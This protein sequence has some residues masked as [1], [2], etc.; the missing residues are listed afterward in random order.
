MLGADLTITNALIL[1]RGPITLGPHNLNMAQGAIIPD[2][3]DSSHV[4]TN[5]TGELRSYGTIS[6]SGQNVVFPIGVTFGRPHIC[7]VM[8]SGTVDEFRA[9]VG[10]TVTS[11]GLPG[12]TPITS[13]VVNG[14]WHVSEGTP[15]GSTF[16]LILYW[17]TFHEATSF[18]RTRSFVGRIVS[19]A[20]Q[21][22]GPVGAATTI[23]TRVHR[24]LTGQTM[25][26]TYAVGDLQS[27]IPVEL[28]LFTARADG[29]DVVL[30]WETADERANAGFEVQRA[31]VDDDAWAVVAFVAARAAEGSGAKYETVD[32]SVAAGTWRYRLRQVDVDGRAEYSQAVT[33]VVGEENAAPL[34]AVHPNPARDVAQVVVRDARVV[35][36]RDVLGREVWRAEVARGGV[37]TLVVPTQFMPAGVYVVETD[38]AR[39]LLRIVR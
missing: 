39:T 19:G 11:N 21:P 30:A 1:S 15:G 29:A 14:M 2:D 37:Q 24:E 20:W 10:G 25:L 6:S 12:G 18:D 31:R 32:R 26:G 17:K 23:G 34:V 36:V 13:D 27:V 22:A 4:I 7:V 8:N 33:V 9:R 35:V 28:V 16:S 5:G 38:L 3:W